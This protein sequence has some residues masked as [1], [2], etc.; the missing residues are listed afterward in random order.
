MVGRDDY[1]SNMSS[2]T[3]AERIRPQAIAL[4][5]AGKS[6]REIREILGVRSNATLNDALAGEPPPEW[7]RRAAAEIGALTKREVLIAGAI[8]YWCEG[9]KWKPHHRQ[10]RVIFVNSDPGLIRFFLKF[11][12]AT[13]AP[14]SELSYRVLIHES[15]DV[16][17]AE[18]FWLSVTGAE[19][20]QF[21]RSSL[22]RHNPKTVRWNVGD[23]YHGCLRLDVRESANLYRRIEGW[24]DAAM[25]PVQPSQQ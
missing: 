23:T 7:T 11:L 9:T 3:L 24:A 12:D 2:I 4:R 8:A 13:G 18:R 20:G 5:R 22:K 6:R 14:R 17:A 19:R 1:G 25:N 15:A 16:A 21:L 10:E